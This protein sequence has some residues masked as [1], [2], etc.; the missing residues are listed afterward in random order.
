MDGWDGMGWDGMGW[1]GMGWDG[2]GWDGMGW[3][4]WMDGWDGW[5]DG[6][7]GWIIVLYVDMFSFWPGN[8]RN[9]IQTWQNSSPFCAGSQLDVRVCVRAC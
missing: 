3:D 4:G 8:R 2:M 5:M 1:D 7:D 9:G 6:W